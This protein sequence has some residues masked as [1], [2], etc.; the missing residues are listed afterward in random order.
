MTQRERLNFPMPPPSPI[1]AA[2]KYLACPILA[3]C[4]LVPIAPAC[5]VLIDGPQQAP[6]LP[7]QDFSAAQAD[8]SL[9]NPS[10]TYA[11][12]PTYGTVTVSYGPYFDGQTA[13]DPLSP[14]TIV[15]G[16]PTNPLTLA[17]DQLVQAPASDP[18]NTDYPY[19]WKTVVQSD[20]SADG[21]YVIGGVPGVIGGQD[22]GVTNGFGGPVAILFSTPVAGVQLTAGYFDS[23]G[24]TQ[25]EG[26]TASGMSIGSLLN[27]LVGF[28]TFYLTDTTP[29]E[30]I[31]GLLLTTTDPGGFGVSGVGLLPSS[32][33][34]PT[35]MPA[36]NGLAILPA[37]ALAGF[38]LRRSRHAWVGAAVL[39]ATALPAA[40]QSLDCVVEP[41]MLVKVG[42]PIA[43]TLESVDVKRGDTVTKGQVLAKLVSGVE[44]ADVALAEAR[45]RS[46]AE[47]DSR[48][49][50]L[51]FAQADLSRG[52]KL[53]TGANI[54]PQKVD[55]LRTNFQVAQQ[56]LVTAELNHQLAILDLA[57]SQALLNARI[58]RSPVD[59]VVTQRSLVP[60][61]FVHQDN[62][63][64]VLAVISP[65]HVQVYPPVPMFSQIKLGQTARVALTEPAGS[66][67]EA[68]VTVVDQLFDAASGTFGVELTMANPD[69]VV[70]AGQ[71][72]R[73]AFG[74]GTPTVSAR[75]H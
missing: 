20:N 9:T 48:R 18:T 36:P 14:P 10:F 37:L 28:E 6:A 32:N 3:L 7:E 12:V 71:R 5:A 38:L 51:E 2:A 57:R 60:G 70:P 69:H 74:E 40:A 59:G 39:L 55:E 17:L 44:I 66:L 62:N 35:P 15:T 63:I 26:F 19:S 52:T 61:E 41:E 73:V 31:S 42:S 8:A 45:A 67:R 24:L 13:T 22:F 29:G 53:L 30:L 49:S 16:T 65:L 64:V 56:D 4:L 1:A 43:T 33:P 72:C 46:T 75:T 34:T 23:P 47:I 54:A 25:I 68:N 58:I 27:T 11:D 21:T 50:K